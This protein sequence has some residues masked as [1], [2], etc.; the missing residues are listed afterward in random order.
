MVETGIVSSDVEEI[1]ENQPGPSKRS[2]TGNAGE[3]KKK[4]TA[5]ILSYNKGKCGI[6]I[7]EQVT[8]YN[9]PLLKELKW[10]RKLGFALLLCMTVVNA[11][12]VYNSIKGRR[13]RLKPLESQ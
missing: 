2:R 10:Y 8:S 5:A 9:T 7:S 6:D 11:W 1:G 4:K 3:G 12:I 13:H